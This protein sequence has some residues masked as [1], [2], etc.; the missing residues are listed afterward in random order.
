VSLEAGLT[1]WLNADP[2][3]VQSVGVRI[4]PMVLPQGVGF[5]TISYYR[6]GQQNVRSLVS[7]SGL[8]QSRMTVDCWALSYTESKEL[9]DL[10]QGNK[11]NPKLDGFRGMMGN[12]KVQACFCTN[13]V[14]LHERPVHADE[15]GVYHTA[16]DFEIWFEDV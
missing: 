4:F 9:A 16:L 11:T 15:R 6:T 13:E 2:D 14:D 7:L 12:V 8:S 1:A 10:I 3:V 5:P